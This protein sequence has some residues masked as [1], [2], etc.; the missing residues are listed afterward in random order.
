MSRSQ[1]I[2]AGW[3]RGIQ[4]VGQRTIAEEF[5]KGRIGGVNNL[6]RDALPRA[7][8]RR[9]FIGIELFRERGEPLDVA[10]EK[11]GFV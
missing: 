10:H 11:D 8:D 6:F 2:E 7:D 9:Q 3:D 5:V 4:P 1:G